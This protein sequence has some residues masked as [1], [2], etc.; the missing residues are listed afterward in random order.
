MARRRFVSSMA[1]AMESV[2]LSAYMCTWPDTLRA[3]RPMVWIRDVEDA[4]PQ[5]AQQ[6]NAA[7]RV[8]VGV[9]VFDLH[10]VAQQVVGEVLGHPFC[11]RGDEDPLILGGPGADFAQQ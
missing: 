4:H 9:Q 11:Q 5:F 6:L 10:A 7:Q 8:D 3:A 2:I 1:W